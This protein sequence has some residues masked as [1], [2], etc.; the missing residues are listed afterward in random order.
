MSHL[1]FISVDFCCPL[2]SRWLICRFYLGLTFNEGSKFPGFE[3]CL[4]PY[5]VELTCSRC[6]GFL[7]KLPHAFQIPCIFG[8]LKTLMASRHC[9]WFAWRSNVGSG[10][11]T[12]AAPHELANIWCWL[13]RS[14]WSGAST[15]LEVRYRLLVV[16]IDWS[17]F[18]QKAPSLPMLEVEERFSSSQKKAIGSSYSNDMARPR[19]GLGSPLRF[20]FWCASCWEQF[21]TLRSCNSPVV[22]LL[23]P[24]KQTFSAASC[25]DCRTFPKYL[26]FNAQK[27]L[28]HYRSYWMRR[29]VIA[30]CA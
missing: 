13:P 17:R 24:P 30:C 8:P 20:S 26:A 28:C 9:V 25:F 27:S 22:G 10:V 18:Q 19:E 23:T 16:N 15:G 7:R 4:G 29:D 12:M 3:S 5:C 21:N 2:F 6:A 11:R 1:L 14:K